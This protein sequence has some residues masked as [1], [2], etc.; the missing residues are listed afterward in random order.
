MSEFYLVKKDGKKMLFSESHNLT[1]EQ[2]KLINHP[3]KFRIIDALAKE[4]MYVAE[5]AKKLKM[6]EQVAYYHIN[7]LLKSGILEISER[8]EIRGTV[9][10]KYRPKKLS[11]SLT[12]ENKWQ[13]V[14]QLI[15]PKLSEG[16]HSLLNPFQKDGIFDGRIIVGSPDPHGPFKAR[17]RDGHY[18][19]DLSLFLGK[20]LDMPEEF[21]VQLDTDANLKKESQN[22]IVI[23]G[24]VT[25]LISSQIN[26]LLPVRFSDKKP[27]GIQS[28]R[29]QR[30]YTDDAVGVISRI[31]NPHFPGRSILCIAGIRAVGTKSAVIGLTRFHD[32]L[33]Q[34]FSGQKKWAV[35]VQGY[36]LNG[37]GKV[38][39]VEVLE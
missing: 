6:H 37:D 32:K 8:K 2:L 25:N 19:I 38:D 10:K 20:Y 21:T 26:E 1:A 33:L 12:L 13:P 18:A 28:E 23:G 4:S 14:Q 35:I 30:K 5:L 39:S 9:A 15:Q 24:P 36:D 31:P 16:L 11:Y 27:W 3:L 34:T 29:T 17:A 22:Y 7:Q